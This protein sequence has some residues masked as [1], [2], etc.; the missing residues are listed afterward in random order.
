MPVKRHRDGAMDGAFPAAN[1]ADAKG[2]DAQGEGE[3][4]ANAEMPAP[5]PRASLRPT[6]RETGAQGGNDA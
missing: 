2:A 1:L 5:V 4:C 3:M 6:T